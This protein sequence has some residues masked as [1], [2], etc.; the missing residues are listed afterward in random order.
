MPARI[1]NLH[2]IEEL[3]KRG[4]VSAELIVDPQRGQIKS[5]LKHLIDLAEKSGVRVTFASD[6]EI[7][8]S[9]GKGQHRGAVLKLE[10][11][12]GVSLKS[13]L[14]RSREPQQLV[15]V[16]DSITDPHNL[17]AI[18]RSADQFNA[19][20]VVIPAHGSAKETETVA[21]VSAGASAWV[22][23]TVE[24]N[25]RNAID[26]LKK[27]GFWV[28][29]ADMKG[30]PITQVRLEGK[31]AIVLGSE[32]KGLRRL[33]RESCDGLISIPSSG[34]VDSF[35][36]SVAASILMYEVRRQQG[37]FSVGQR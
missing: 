17:G 9:I 12:A 4:H 5:R 2:A 27:E 23:V 33:V 10:A 26:L 1:T 8:R 24:S 21:G 11:G 30:E 22:T 13:A 34:H 3:L 31:I 35:N 6:E 18:L 20:A 7:T 15:L 29:G 37:Y 32:G 16:L 25:I 36:V 19:D 14:K 28:F